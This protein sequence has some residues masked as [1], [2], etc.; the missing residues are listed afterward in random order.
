MRG[1]LAEGADV[2]VSVFEEVWLDKF[3]LKNWKGR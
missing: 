3:G 1:K 2:K